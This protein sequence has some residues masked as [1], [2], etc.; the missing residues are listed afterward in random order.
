MLAQKNNACL[1]RMGTSLIYQQQYGR[2]AAVFVDT[3]GNSFAGNKVSLVLWQSS[4]S[5]QGSLHEKLSPLLYVHLT[6]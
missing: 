5:L 6:C 1:S 4:I 3:A 2:E